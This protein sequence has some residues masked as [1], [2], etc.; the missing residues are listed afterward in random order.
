[1]WL[2]RIALDL[3]GKSRIIVVLFAF[4]GK[5]LKFS[6]WFAKMKL[7]LRLVIFWF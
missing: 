2:V 3:T 4:R 7:L 1:M 6:A 5:V